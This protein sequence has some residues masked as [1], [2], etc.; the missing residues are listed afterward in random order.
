MKASVNGAER[1]LPAGTTLEWLLREIGVAPPGLAV[2]VNE[3]VVR[4]SEYGSIELADGDRIE[5]VRAVAGGF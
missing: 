4:G 2:A 1:E 3:R 5:I